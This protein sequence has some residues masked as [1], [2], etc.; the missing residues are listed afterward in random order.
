M[1]DTDQELREKAA[2]EIMR[3]TLQETEAAIAA[4]RRNR[5]W[6]W[7]RAIAGANAVLALLPASLDRGGEEDIDVRS[8][9]MPKKDGSSQGSQDRSA[10]G[11]GAVAHAI[12]E[13]ERVGQAAIRIGEA[14]FTLP[15]PNR[16][17]NILWWL[18]VL[19]VPS[20]LTHDQGFVTS[21][22]RYVDRLE[23]AEIA[24]RSGQ[25]QTLISPPHLYSEDLWDGGAEMISATALRALANPEG[26]HP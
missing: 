1:S 19:S 14:V 3:V 16:H 13:A 7:E 24:Q 21:A 5:S 8:H 18:S 20:Q 15:R 10:S 26:D 23:A 4:A 2:A 11:R 25:V 22:G 17:H 6:V 12:P 9:S